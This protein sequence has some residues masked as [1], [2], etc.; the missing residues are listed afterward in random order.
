MG[1]NPKK[2]ASNPKQIPM[3]KMP[4]TKTT[5]QKSESQENSW[6]RWIWETECVWNLVLV[7]CYLFVICYLFQDLL[8]HSSVQT[9]TYGLSTRIQ[10]L[11]IRVD[12]QTSVDRG[13][14][15]SRTDRVV[16]YIGGVSV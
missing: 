7:F 8:D 5:L 1:I 3:F 11:R 10:R 4:R 14:N 12:A 9:D 6:Q 15:I 13:A 16:C 2:Q